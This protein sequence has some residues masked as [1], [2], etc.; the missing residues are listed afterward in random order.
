AE[1][2]LLDPDTAHPRL[3]LS[4]DC[5]SVR[6]GETEQDL[7]DSRKRFERLC[8]VL[9]REGFSAGRHCWEVEGEVGDERRWAVGVANDLLVTRAV[10]S[11]SPEEWI[12]AVQQRKGKFVALTDPRT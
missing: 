4:Q 8:C 7:P 3:V 9:G 10:M 11:P 1:E 2:V 5:R 12:W 6:W